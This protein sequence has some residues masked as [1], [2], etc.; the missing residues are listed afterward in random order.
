VEAEAACVIPQVLHP[1]EEMAA[2]VQEAKQA[3]EPQEVQTRVVE[4]GELVGKPITPQVVPLVVQALSL[5]GT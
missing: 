5:L 2:V 3:Q 1:L 4:A